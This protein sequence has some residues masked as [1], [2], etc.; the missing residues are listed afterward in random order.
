MPQVAAADLGSEALVAVHQARALVQHSNV[1]N[2]AEVEA[3]AMG[4]GMS[5]ASISGNGGS[6]D[7]GGGLERAQRALQGHLPDGM[8][9]A[10]GA[11]WALPQP[12]LGAAAAPSARL[13]HGQVRSNAAAS[14][15]Y[16]PAHMHMPVPGRSGTCKRQTVAHLKEST[17]LRC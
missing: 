10:R 16:M 15:A 11:A 3:S 8:T 17:T 14:Q 5:G 6:R 1:C 4:S 12:G 2:L 9:P 13:L 7:E